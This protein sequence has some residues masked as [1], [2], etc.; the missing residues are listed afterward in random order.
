MI[1]IL[2]LFLWLFATYTL[3]TSHKINYVCVCGCVNDRIF[4]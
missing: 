4:G 2:Q 3:L 1:T